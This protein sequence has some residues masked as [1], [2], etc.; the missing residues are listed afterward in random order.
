MHTVCKFRPRNVESVG[1]HQE[2]L[3]KVVRLPVGSVGKK[4]WKKFNKPLEFFAHLLKALDKPLKPLENPFV[5]HW[6]LP[7]QR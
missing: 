1:D 6:I 3:K 5:S 4:R 2:P 7:I